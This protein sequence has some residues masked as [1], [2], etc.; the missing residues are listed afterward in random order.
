MPKLP[1]S[2]IDFVPNWQL[3]AC[4]TVLTV[5]VL[6]LTNVSFFEVHNEKNLCRCV[7]SVVVA[8]RRMQDW[9][10]PTQWA[11]VSVQCLL[12]KRVL[13]LRWYI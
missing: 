12:A 13:F 3:P 10:V 1:L 4:S 2:H 6:L 8:N 9:H 5:T 7:F 11:D